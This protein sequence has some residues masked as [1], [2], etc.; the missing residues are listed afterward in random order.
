MEGNNLQLR[1]GFA[2][3]ITIEIPKDIKVTVPNPQRII[4]QGIDLQRVTQFA[5]GVRKWRKPEPYNQ[6]GVFVGNETI[7]KKE[8]KK[9]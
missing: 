7:R 2:N 5:A 9:R 8:G 6:K 1:L 4:V 3:P